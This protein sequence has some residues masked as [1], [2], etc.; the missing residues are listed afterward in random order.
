MTPARTNLAGRATVHVVLLAYTA[1][2]LAPVLLVVVNSLKSRAA[3]FGAP[4]APARAPGPSTSS[5]TR[6]CS[7]KAFS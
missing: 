1:L 7:A 5:V 2:C 3:I 6:P 4:L